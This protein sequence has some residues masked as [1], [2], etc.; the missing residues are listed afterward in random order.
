MSEIEQNSIL[1]PGEKVHIIEKRFFKEDTRRHFVG[2]IVQCTE[3]NIRVRGYVWAC[4]ALKGFN[5]KPEIRERIFSLHEGLII[6]IVPPEVNL[7]ELKYVN[8]LH[9][10]LFVID[11]KNFSLDITEFTIG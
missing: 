3:S 1:K 9:K 8:I 4:E 5:K 6:N 11:G 10:G 2:E 7:E